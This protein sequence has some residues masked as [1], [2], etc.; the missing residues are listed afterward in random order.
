MIVLN[1]ILFLNLFNFSS[2]SIDLRPTCTEKIIMI[3]ND[4]YRLDSTT[5]NFSKIKIKYNEISLKNY[6]KFTLME[7]EVFLNNSSGILYELKNDSILRLDK[8]YDDKIHNKSLN[9]KYNDTLYRFGG[10]GY[11]TSNKNLVFY[12]KKS[13]DWR[14]VKFNG[15]EKIEPFSSI[16]FHYIEGD[17]LFVL[18]MNYNVEDLRNDNI[19]LRDQNIGFVFDLKNKKIVRTLVL[20]KTFK[21]P[22]SYIRIN[23]QF[24]FLFY[25]DEQLIKV[26]DT[27]TND[28]FVYNS[29]SNISYINNKYD[30][31]FIIDEGKLY[32][33][34]E[35]INKE[36]RIENLDINEILD[37][38]KITNIKILEEN[39]NYFLFTMLL[40]VFVIFIFLLLRKKIILKRQ[41]YING[42]VLFFRN[43]KITLS[44]IQSSYLKLMIE[45]GSINSDEFNSF[46]EDKN[47][48]RSHVY[49]L[50]NNS[51]KEF[52]LIFETKFG[53]KIIL[54]KKNDLDKRMTSYFINPKFI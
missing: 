37:N 31:N 12:N 27:K 20:N 6:F 7:N 53:G 49:R 18:G 47:L 29:Q 34:I 15:F 38:K 39:N 52:N 45:K 28:V 19:K 23:R 35:D 17:F 30:N 24:L 3:E 48:N 4:L 14:L 51:L 41:L 44:P 32:F 25:P 13:E 43:E 8:S 21:P 2:D 26:Y 11:F 9:F 36:L 16:G 50:K 46:F 42:D 54:F 10:Y 22:Q 33:I 1:I 40:F 5:N